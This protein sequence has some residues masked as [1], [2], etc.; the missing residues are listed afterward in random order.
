MDLTGKVSVVTGA[1]QGNGFGIARA[2]AGAGSQVIL[3]DRNA[4][5]LERAIEELRGS[6]GD[7]TPF[8]CD[9]TEED[10]VKELMR[11]AH[12]LGGPHVLVSQAGLDYSALIPDTSLEDW[13]RV[14]GVDV[15]ATFLCVREAIP[16][17]VDLGG[18]SII[19]MSGTYAWVAEPGHALHA[20]AKGAIM[21]FTRGI[22]C[23]WGHKGIRA[24]ALN[25][26]WINTPMVSDTFEIRPAEQTDEVVKWHALGRIGEIDE[27][28]NLALFLASDASSFCTG[29]AF[30]I[31]GG[32]SAGVNSFQKPITV[33]HE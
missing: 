18:G 4:P 29:A 14:M 1:A 3:A 8:V 30:T 20:A 16:Y 5:R 31:D 32:Q 13:N 6:G 27:I 33:K 15:T 17:M 10:A 9:V 24:N 12:E 2:L 7:V 25:P 19:T 11:S 23:E 22:A 28:G 21:S 26:G